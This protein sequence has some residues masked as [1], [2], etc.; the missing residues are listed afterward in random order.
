MT[1][2]YLGLPGLYYVAAVHEQEHDSISFFSVWALLTCR[3]T[4][5]DVCGI[6]EYYLFVH[7]REHGS[8]HWERRDGWGLYENG[9][10]CRDTMYMGSKYKNKGAW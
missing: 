8:S 2:I 9:I 10:A 3:R 1:K 7:I 4:K 6:H 5:S